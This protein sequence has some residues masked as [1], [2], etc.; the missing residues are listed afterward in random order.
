MRL[1]KYNHCKYCGTYDVEIIMLRNEIWEKVNPAKKGW[2][3]VSCIEQR[4]DRLI[5]SKDLDLCKDKHYREDMEKRHKTR[6]V[7]HEVAKYLKEQFPGIYDAVKR[8]MV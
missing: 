3:C 8:L 2:V 5:T 6:K 4:L 7:D 1:D